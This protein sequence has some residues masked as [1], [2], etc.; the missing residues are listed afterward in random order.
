MTSILQSEI[1]SRVASLKLNG[2][3]RWHKDWSAPG[4]KKTKKHPQRLGQTRGRDSV[5][6][7]GGII[8]DEFQ[9]ILR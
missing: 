3:G 9:I 8:R 1:N 4:K 7:W 5:T 6:F 2:P